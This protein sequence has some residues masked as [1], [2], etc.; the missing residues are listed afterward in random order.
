M[1]VNRLLASSPR[2]SA[3]YSS[4]SAHC[5]HRSVSPPGGPP[6][7][8]PYKESKEL[9]NMKRFLMHILPLHTCDAP[10]NVVSDFIPPE[11]SLYL[12]RKCIHTR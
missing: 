3:P 2:H 4:R 6:S 8:S 1:L 12:K 5:F 7:S 9:Q 11:H 10:T